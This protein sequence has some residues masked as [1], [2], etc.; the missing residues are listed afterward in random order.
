MSHPLRTVLAYGTL[1]GLIGFTSATAQDFPNIP[2]KSPHYFESAQ[3]EI[4]TLARVYSECVRT[5]DGTYDCSAEFKE[6]KAW[7]DGLVTAVGLFKER[8]KIGA[9][10]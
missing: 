3:R 5:S 9:C 8:Q 6:L 10:D 7:Q 2:C 1:A 4:A